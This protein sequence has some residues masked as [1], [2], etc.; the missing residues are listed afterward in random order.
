MTTPNPERTERNFVA[1]AESSHGLQIVVSF[2]PSFLF[3]SQEKIYVLHG[4]AD[5]GHYI[6]STDD[7]NVSREETGKVH[8]RR[9]RIENDADLYTS[10]TH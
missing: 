2:P 6:C 7:V 5:S 1:V 8:T 3:W 10:T 4:D 9:H